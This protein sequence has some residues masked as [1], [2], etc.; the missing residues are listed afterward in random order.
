MW[1]N[2]LNASTQLTDR[3]D[4]NQ[5]RARLCANDRFWYAELLLAFWASIGFKPG[6]FITQV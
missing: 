5:H 3:A 4:Y 6:D 2:L 1:V